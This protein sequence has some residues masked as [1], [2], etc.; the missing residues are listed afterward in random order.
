MWYII[1]SIIIISIAISLTYV[2]SDY[3]RVSNSIVMLL[4]TSFIL[5]VL[6]FPV[7]QT[8]TG[9]FRDYAQGEKVGYI[10]KLSHEGIVWKTIEGEMQLGVGELASIE[11]LFEFSIVKPEVLKKIKPYVGSNQKI[12]ITYKGWLLM[13]WKLGSSNYEVIQIEKVED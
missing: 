2:Q 12:K 3:Y 10:T 11:G 6:S 4:A 9:L 13:P 1:L 8:T 7:Y 5:F